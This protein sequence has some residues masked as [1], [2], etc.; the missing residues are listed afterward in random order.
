MSNTNVALVSIAMTS[1]AYIGV[2]SWMAWGIWKG[3][4]RNRMAEET[5]KIKVIY[6]VQVGDQYTELDSEFRFIVLISELV[7][8]LHPTIKGPVAPE[9]I[10]ITLRSE[11]AD[12]PPAEW[13][14]V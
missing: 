4:R 10:H 2:M 6:R 1:A 7:R 11:P 13:R 14:K 3:W 12:P 5:K 9:D 8:G